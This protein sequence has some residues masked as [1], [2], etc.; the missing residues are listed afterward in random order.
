MTLAFPLL[1]TKTAK[2]VAMKNAIGLGALL[3][4]FSLSYSYGGPKT[5]EVKEDTQEMTRD[6][7][8]GMKKAGRTVEDKTCELFNGETECAVKKGVNSIKNGSDKI[9]DAVE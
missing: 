5:N 4:I 6:A 9:E 3:A 7:G 1:L 8:R 2:G